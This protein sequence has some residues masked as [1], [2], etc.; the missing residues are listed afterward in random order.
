MPTLIGPDWTGAGAGAGA[1]STGGA[2]GVGGAAGTTGAVSDG[3]RAGA[4]V[5][6]GLGCGAGLTIFTCLGGAGLAGSG[7][8]GSGWRTGCGGVSGMMFTCSSGGGSWRSGDAI[9]PSWISVST[10]A[11][12]SSTT[13][14]ILRVRG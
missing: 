3:G 2:G 13:T 11:C 7:L 10:P 4:G 9:S 5:G 6:A 14:R 1:A 12:N 8:G